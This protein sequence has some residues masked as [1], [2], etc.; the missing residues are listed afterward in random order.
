MCREGGWGSRISSGG[1]GQAGVVIWGMW[2]RDVVGSGVSSGGVQGRTWFG[3]CFSLKVC[4]DDP[5]YPSI[6]HWLTHLTLHP[7]PLP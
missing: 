7:S 4:W 6:P 2:D 1:C 5:S 3:K